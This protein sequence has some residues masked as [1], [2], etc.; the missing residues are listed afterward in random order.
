MVE[1]RN[2]LRPGQKW[3]TYRKINLA[4]HE[5]ACC[6]AGSQL[7]TVDMELPIG[8]V[9]T[10]VPLCREIRFAEQWHCLARAGAQLGLYL[11]YPANSAELVRVWRV[12]LISRAAETQRY[13]V[14]AN[15]ADPS[16]HC[17]TMIV[18]PRGEVLEE[19]NSDAT[20]IRHQIDLTTVRDGYLK[21]QRHDVGSLEY[22]EPQ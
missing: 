21:Q 14:P 20:V 13:V 2:V 8:R 1:R 11:T 6:R 15:L 17:P 10:G 12:H 4:M 9:R 16:Q 5:G 3:W 19:A 22:H 7:T 18:S